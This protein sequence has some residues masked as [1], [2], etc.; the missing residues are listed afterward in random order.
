MIK[1]LT[2]VIKQRACS[3]LRTA[4]HQN[5]QLQASAEVTSLMIN[6]ITIYTI[7]KL[8]EK[9]TRSSLSPDICN[10]SAGTSNSVSLRDVIATQRECRFSWLYTSNFV[11]YLTE[12]L[13]V[14][15][16][17]VMSFRVISHFFKKHFHYRLPKM[18]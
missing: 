18:N 5:Q 14:T 16:N 8:L 12:F 4:A 1:L 3:I 15:P 10:K 6:W 2:T 7:K 13:P 17:S 11:Y 9:E